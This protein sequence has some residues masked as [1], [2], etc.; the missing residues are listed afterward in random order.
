[1][2][3]QARGKGEGEEASKGGRGRERRQ[4]R[5]SGGT[6]LVFGLNVGAK[7]EKL[8]DS[9]EVS[10]RGGGAELFGRLGL[11]SAIMRKGG[12]KWEELL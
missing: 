4:A 3:G 2:R 10:A 6:N 12:K 5:R 11:G 1:M 9:L 8:G 7:G